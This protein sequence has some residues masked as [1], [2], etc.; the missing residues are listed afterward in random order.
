[1]L[2][3]RRS[4]FYLQAI[5]FISIGVAEPFK[6]AAANKYMDDVLKEVVK[7]LERSGKYTIPL[8]RITL[9]EGREDNKVLLEGILGRLDGVVTNL[10]RSGVCLRHEKREENVVVSCLLNVNGV[11]LE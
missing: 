2:K 8:R 3:W 7:K 5:F 9:V 10:R 6:S 11:T 1:M 4:V